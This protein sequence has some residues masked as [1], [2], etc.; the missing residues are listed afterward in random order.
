MENKTNNKNTKN[1]TEYDIYSEDGLITGSTEETTAKKT[2]E[3]WFKVKITGLINSYKVHDDGSLQVKFQE[4]IE[5]ELQGVKYNDYEDRSVRIRIEG[6]I[7]TDEDGKKLLNKFVEIK[8]V[9]ET[10]QY[11]KIT[12]GEYDFS[13][14]EKYVYSANNI[15][16]INTK[17]EGNYKLYKI[18][19]L[20]VKDI[21]PAITYNQR[22]RRQEIDKNSTV[23]FYE[24]SRDTLNSIHK[25][26]VEG[27]ILSAAKPLKD[28][29]IVV[30]DLQIRGNNNYYCS[31]I[32]QK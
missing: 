5:K 19:E 12:D 9:T 23:L 16:L 26:T 27:L 31:K 18:F 11:R 10:A 14:V 1:N 21:A 30:M 3:E 22:L 17:V 8:N 15:N 2:I 29:E 7:F 13:K 20:R 32:K 6:K 28:K 25:I 24:T 4:V